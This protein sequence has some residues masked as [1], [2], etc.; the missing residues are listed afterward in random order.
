MRFQHEGKEYK[1]VF[2]YENY[3]GRRGIQCAVFYIERNNDLKW[4]TMVSS[5]SSLCSKNDRFVK[6]TGR[7]IA[8]RRAADGIEDKNLKA[9]VWTAYMNRK[10]APIVVSIKDP[11]EQASSGASAGPE[12]YSAWL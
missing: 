8:L 6:E 1:V 3:D 2:R 10:N 7:M 9:A 12:T 11:K 5:A 4:T